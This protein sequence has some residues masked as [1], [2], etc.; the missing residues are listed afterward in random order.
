[1]IYLYSGTPGSGKSLHTAKVVYE[2]LRLGLP[3]IA[4]F[5]FNYSGKKNSFYYVDNTELTPDYLQDFARQYW[6]GKCVIE[7]RILL[8]IDE[9]NFY[10]ML[11]NGMQK[12][13]QNGLV[14]IPSIEKW[15]TILY[16]LPYLTG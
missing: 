12:A 11:V 15:A 16:L 13:V 3:V 5:S 2:T 7:G 8:V 6:N 14:S 9:C 1:M 10:L 4:N